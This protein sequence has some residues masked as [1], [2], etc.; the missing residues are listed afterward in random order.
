MN[1]KVDTGKE[2]KRARFVRVAERRTVRVLS[3]LRL[4]SQ[5]SNRRT[6]EYS[7]EQV[8]RIFREIRRTLHATEEKFSE[9][10]AK[11]HF[12]LG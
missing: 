4:L 3:D 1:A 9:S 2:S 6:Y 7:P 12:K 8:R 11:T 10:G 5:C